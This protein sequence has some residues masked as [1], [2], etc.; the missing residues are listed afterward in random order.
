MTS[1]Y[2]ARIDRQIREATERGDFDS[3]PGKGKPL[4]DSGTPL[5]ENWWLK[6]YLAREDVGPEALPTTLRLRREAQDI[7]RTVARETSEEQVRAIV[8][9]L[10]GRILAARLGPVD[11][12]PIV[13]NTVDA[14][15][16]VAV[17]R[18]ART[19]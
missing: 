3:L 14:A 12:P 9:E 5:D 4:P 2:E 11:G 17:W 1:Q 6:S 7:Q 15:E 19:A 10:N 16:V 8:A 18:A 13:V